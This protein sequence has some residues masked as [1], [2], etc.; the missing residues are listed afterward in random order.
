[1]VYLV[2]AMLGGFVIG[3]IVPSLGLSIFISACWGLAC[4]I[5]HEEIQTW[6]KKFKSN[7]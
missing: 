3:Q 4:G 1:M 6:W 7:F 5:Y 2:V